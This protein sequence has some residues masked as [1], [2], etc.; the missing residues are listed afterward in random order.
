MVAKKVDGGEFMIIYGRVAVLEALKS[1]KTF[2]KLQVEKGQKDKTIQEIIDLARENGIKVDF[3]EKEMIE[4][5]AKSVE[6]KGKV[7]HQGVIG[8]TVEFEY[9]SVEEIVE[10]ESDFIVLLDGVE[11]PHNLGAIVRTVECAGASGIIIPERRACNINE[12]VIKTSA[13]AISNVKV[14]RV[15]NLVQTI[16]KLKKDGF[17]IYAIEVGGENLFKSNLK[18]KIAI[19]LGSEGKGVG[20][21]VKESCDGILTIPMFGKINSLNVSVAAAISIFEVIKQK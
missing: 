7:N 14:A 6:Q 5:K 4:R 3:V 1:E 17:W 13:G 9:S 19:V 16:E 20:R 21:L 11:D 8:E 12:T 18:G 15:G 10:D 2:N